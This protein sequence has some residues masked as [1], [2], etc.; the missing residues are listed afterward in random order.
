LLGFQTLKYRLSS[1]I[2]RGVSR[3]S[4][5][6]NLLFSL[7][8]ASSLLSASERDYDYVDYQILEVD[9]TH[10]IPEIEI[11]SIHGF[12]RIRNVAHYKMADWSQVVGIAKGITMK[13]AYKI[14]KENPEITFFFRTKGGP[15]VLE[16][17]DGSYRV[18]H[19]GDTVF[20]SGEPSW[21]TAEGLAD[22]YVRSEK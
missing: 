4:K 8:I 13:E 11:P 6:K 5:M 21:G 10:Q 9:I 2:I 15:M 14:T 7:C 22:G 18:F 19:R 16:R 17:D 3:R 20:F 12:K 1:E